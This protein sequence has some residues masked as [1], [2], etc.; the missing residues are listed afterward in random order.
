[1]DVGN[2]DEQKH[3]VPRAVTIANSTDINKR[4]HE[5]EFRLNVTFRI[6]F[7]QL[8]SLHIKLKI[9]FLKSA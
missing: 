7:V 6:N 3:V 9:F 8:I 1:M 4:F 5:V 2:E